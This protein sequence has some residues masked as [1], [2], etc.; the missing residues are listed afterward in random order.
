[1]RRELNKAWAIWN[2][3]RDI[4]GSRRPY[5][6]GYGWFGWARFPHLSGY[7]VA[8]FESRAVARDAM[9]AL[10]VKGEKR[11]SVRR[12]AIEIKAVP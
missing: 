9:K 10:Q 3:Y 2:D 8:T 4:D 7:V 12:V 11:L 1:M 5:F 6:L